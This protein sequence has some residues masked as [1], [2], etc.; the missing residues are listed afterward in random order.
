MAKKYKCMFCNN[1]FERPKLIAHINKN[2]SDMLPEGYTG[3][4]LVFD[5]LN[6]IQ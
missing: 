6:T 4:R 2:H 3:A 5:K 1:S